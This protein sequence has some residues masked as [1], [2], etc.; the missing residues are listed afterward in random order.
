MCAL[1]NTLLYLIQ[2][3]T[4]I[5]AGEGVEYASDV[6]LATLALFVLVLDMSVIAR[7]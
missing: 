7:T 5:L 2:V 4:S 1:F 3:I 6:G